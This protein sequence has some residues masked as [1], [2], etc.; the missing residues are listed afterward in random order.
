MTITEYRHRLNE[1]LEQLNPEAL[2]T[3]LF[4]LA[5]A[6]YAPKGRVVS[7]DDAVSGTDFLDDADEQLAP[8]APGVV[9]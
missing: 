6:R 7:E 3:R 9:R 8:F 5:L 1:R 2:R 4:H